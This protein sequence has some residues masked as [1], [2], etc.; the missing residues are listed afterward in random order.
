MFAR[1]GGY[2]DKVEE[3]EEVE[4][5]GVDQLPPPVAVEEIAA[6][7]RGPPDHV[8]VEVT[9]TLLPEEQRHEGDPHARIVV[10]G[11]YGGAGQLEDR[12]GHVGGGDRNMRRA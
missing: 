4:V 6:L 7:E 1:F 2:T 12:G 9:A 3:R 10:R 5:G 11:V 8:A